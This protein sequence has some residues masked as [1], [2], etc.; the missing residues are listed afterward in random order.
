[1]ERLRDV[2]RRAVEASHGE[3]EPALIAV[4]RQVRGDPTLLTEAAQTLADITPRDPELDVEIKRVWAEVGGNEERAVNAIFEQMDA[5]ENPS[6]AALV[7]QALVRGLGGSLTN[8]VAEEVSRWRE[9]H[10]DSPKPPAPVEPEARIPFGENQSDS[11]NPIPVSVKQ[12]GQGFAADLERVRRGLVGQLQH[13]EC[14]ADRPSLVQSQSFFWESTLFVY[15]LYAFFIM[16]EFGK[17]NFTELDLELRVHI[18]R[19]LIDRGVDPA[20]HLQY[21]DHL[22]ARRREYMGHLDAALKDRDSMNFWLTAWLNLGGGPAGTLMGGPVLMSQ[23][24]VIGRRLKGVSRQ[25]V[26]HD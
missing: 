15:A 11:G 7:F 5:R 2:V 13:T 18:L 6:V 22:F 10:L 8:L 17:Q 19:A 3:A 23:L 24:E 26:I 14:F 21:Q 16:R 4:V 12:L 9:R 20:D 1:M 25:F